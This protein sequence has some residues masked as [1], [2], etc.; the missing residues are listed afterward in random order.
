MSNGVGAL[1]LRM[2]VFSALRTAEQ[3]CV[4][5]L[6]GPAGSLVC[7]ACA[8]AL[9]RIQACCIRCALPLPHAAVC[10]SCLR[11]APPFESALAVYEYGFPV[12]R[13][14]QR[15]K[16]SGDLAVGRWLA[17]RLADRAGQ[18]PR[19]SFVVPMPLS[20]ERLK[21]RGFNQAGEIARVVARSIGAPLDLGALERTRDTSAQ[22][23]LS[24]R[25]RRANL[26]GAFRCPRG[27]AG[28]DV[29]LVDDVITTGATANEA[30]RALKRAGAASVHVWA[31]ARTP[32]GGR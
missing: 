31:I 9:P 24:R 21:M 13:L 19:P 7:R 11:A 23:G 22:S 28:K 32:Q 5:C 20:R 17:L 10:G 29:A 30:A 14:L 27:L 1:A 25:A 4:L 26:R 6:A 16:F 8:C 15:F 12:D 18:A 3:D 2:P